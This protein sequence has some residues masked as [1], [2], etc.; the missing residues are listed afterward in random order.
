LV[1]DIDFFK[2]VNDAHG[3][4]VG[5]VVI[6]GLGEILRRAKR[7]NDVVARF[8]GEEFV[9]VCEETDAKGAMLLAE[10]IRKEVETCSFA[11]PDGPLKVTCS[12]GIATFPEA[13]RDWESLFRAADGA[14]YVSK[15]GGR[16]RSTAWSSQRKISAA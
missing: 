12:I 16:N 5:D 2:K 6:R 10:R 13:G 8:G 14:L 4:D 9:V 3:H 1:T 7:A 15:S 11:T